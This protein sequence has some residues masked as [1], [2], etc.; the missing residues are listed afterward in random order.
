MHFH[1]RTAELQRCQDT[2][3]PD[4]NRTNIPGM[5]LHGTGGVGK[6]SIALELT[7]R[8]RSK[9]E[10]ILWLSADNDNK[11]A[12][13]FARVAGALGIHCQNAKPN[14][15]REAVLELLESTSKYCWS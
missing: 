8:E 11:L 6:T 15:D 7:Y 10:I 13:S 12:A 4:P 3:A 9:R 2:L 5:V 1:G 14:A